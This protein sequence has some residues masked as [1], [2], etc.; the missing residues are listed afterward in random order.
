LKFDFLL[1]A[2]PVG[3]NRSI[4]LAVI[5]WFSF[6]LIAVLAE[7]FHHKIN[8]YLI[9][10]NVFWHVIQ[11][12]NLYAAYPA[13]YEDHNF[14]GPI[15]SFIIAPFAV[16]PNYAGVIL[17]VLC[18][19]FLLYYAIRRLPLTAKAIN[20]IFLIAAIEFM[21]SSHNVQFNPIVAAGI[22]LSYVFVKEEK[23]FWAA[24]FIA[25]GFLAKI[26]GI[27][28]LLFFVFSRHKIKFLGSFLF[29]LIVLFCLPMLISSHGFI[30]QTY[31]DWVHTLALKNI[32]NI[33][34][35]YVSM[36][37]LT[38]M[39]IIRRTFNWP[40]FSSVIVLAPAAML[41]AL[42]LLR[43]KLYQN[44]VYQLYYLSLALITVVIY[45]SSA[46][47]ATYVIA[48]V[49]V[50]I[51]FVLNMHKKNTATTVVLVF[52][53]F[54]TS[55]SS[56]DLVP[57]FIKHDIIRRYALKALPCFIIWLILVYNVAFKKEEELYSPAL[58][59][60]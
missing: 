2:V 57:Q 51:W 39:G 3:K 32:H 17:W 36:Q 41:L 18:N 11:Q 30:I 29:W 9:F 58:A 34:L 28:G 21:T 56:T 13:E 1:K 31:K 44:T 6:A 12:K 22:I 15:F 60:R 16:L 19:A 27:M 35:D 33:T 52:A 8:N 54:V 37:D 40:Q 53:L 26:Y 7:T 46:E 49:G 38:V 43:F 14:Y 50:A 47:S 48:M 25:L 59:L 24:F 23:D 4:P 45:S 20:L 5:I 42:P 55:L 10:K